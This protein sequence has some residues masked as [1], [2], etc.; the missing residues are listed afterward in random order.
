MTAPRHVFRW[1]L[2]K[3][4]LYSEFER[5]RDLVKSALEKPADKRAVPGAPA[6]LRA[7]RQTPGH[8][9]CIVSGS[10][11]QMRRALQAKLRLDGVEYDEFVLKDNIRN[12]VRGRFRALRAQIPY[13]LPVLLRSRAALDGSP[14]E[15]LVGDDAESD[16]LIYSLYADLLDGRIADDEL[17]RIM[18]A[19]RAYDDQIAEASALARR[20]PVAPGSVKRILIHLDQRSPTARFTK[21]GRRLVPIYNYFQAALI[22]YADGVLTAR[23]VLFVALEMLADD[24]YE[25]PTLANSLQDLVIRGRLHRDTAVQL[26]AECTDAAA[27][28]AL[29]GHDELPPFEQIAESFKER[30]RV[31]GDVPPLEWPEADPKIDYVDLVDSDHSRRRSKRKS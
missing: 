19:D 16:A 9:I 26:A 14:P 31:L 10:P 17:P 13:K 28:G 15:T 22:L 20:I 18:A 7:L 12:L 29:A 27:E 30:V 21:Y 25:L 5:V 8:R 1:D 24:Q 3:T 2:D 4:Y 11:E 6:L 23:Q